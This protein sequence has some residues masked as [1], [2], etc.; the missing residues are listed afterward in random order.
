MN[1]PHPYGFRPLGEAKASLALM[2][3]GM[4]FKAFAEAVAGVS[5]A[6]AAASA[7][8]RAALATVA[9]NAPERLK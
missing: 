7:A 6:G 8:L 9:R 4:N 1:R 3:L 2:R 5:L